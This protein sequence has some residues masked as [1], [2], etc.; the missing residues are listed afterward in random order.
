MIALE[1]RDL[2][3][4]C[5]DSGRFANQRNLLSQHGRFLLNEEEA[6]AILNKIVETVRNS[7]RPAM[8]E[9]GVSERDCKKIETAFLYKGFFYP[10]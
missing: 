8:K 2:A 6:S 10:E 5:G 7:W 1:R 3:T 4:A 9:S